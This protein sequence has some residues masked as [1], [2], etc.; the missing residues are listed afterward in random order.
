MLTLCIIF[1]INT[2][3]IKWYKLRTGNL[4]TIVFVLSGL[5]EIFKINK[6]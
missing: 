5:S 4:F 3:A 2:F 1:K 6:L